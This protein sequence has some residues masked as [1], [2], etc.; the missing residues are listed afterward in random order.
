[1]GHPTKDSGICVDN[2][3]CFKIFWKLLKRGIFGQVSTFFDC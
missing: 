3:R 1:M 2:A